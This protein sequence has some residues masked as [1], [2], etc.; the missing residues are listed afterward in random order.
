[1]YL[2]VSVKHLHPCYALLCTCSTFW[3]CESLSTWTSELV[4][5]HWLHSSTCFSTYD[6]A[7]YSA[8][9]QLQIIDGLLKLVRKYASAWLDCEIQSSVRLYLLH[10]PLE[11]VEDKPPWKITV[12]FHHYLEVPTP[13]H[14]HALTRVTRL[15]LSDHPLAVEQLRRTSRYHPSVPHAHCLCRLCRQQVESP[16]HI[17][18][19]CTASSALHNLRHNFLIVLQTKGLHLP[20]VT[21]ANAALTLPDI[22][23]NRSSVNLL[24]KFVYDALALVQT[25]PLYRPW[26][27]L[28][29]WV[30][31]GLSIPPL[32]LFSASVLSFSLQIYLWKHVELVYWCPA[33]AQKWGL[34]LSQDFWNPAVSSMG[35]HRV[36]ILSYP[37]NWFVRISRKSITEAFSKT[38]RFQ[39]FKSQQFWILNN[40]SKLK[41]FWDFSRNPKNFKINE[42]HVNPIHYSDYKL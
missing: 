19:L 10:G 25:T 33:G 26:Y 21:A 12:C 37:V 9:L 7:T 6:L 30:R 11:P 24:A 38:L 36:F 22:L 41:S 17:L 27:I 8:Q 28:L 39:L 13:K 5:G 40:F 20:V 18:L 16:E 14:H 29:D 4:H 34:W 3:L 15:L 35:P 32:S 23:Y 2:Q 42:I 31:L 1:M